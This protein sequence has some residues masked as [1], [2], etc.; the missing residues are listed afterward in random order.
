MSDCGLLIGVGL[1]AGTGVVIAGGYLGYK[2]LKKKNPKLLERITAD[3]KH[4][5]SEGFTKAYS[6]HAGD[7]VSEKTIR[8]KSSRLKEL[9]SAFSEG[10]DNACR[11]PQSQ[12]GTVALA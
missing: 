4:G 11:S 9:T 8:S 10:F 5:F 7:E 1:G 6:T 12:N 3:V 2:V